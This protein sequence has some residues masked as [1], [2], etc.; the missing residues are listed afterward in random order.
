MKS[1]KTTIIG[2]LLAGVSFLGIYQSNGGNLSDW[3]QWVIP[4]LIAVLGYLAKDS[5]VTGPVKAIGFMLA[6]SV[7]LTSCGGIT[8]A[9][10]ERA[11]LDIALASVS[12]YAQGGKAGAASGGLN[13][14]TSNL[15]ALRY[16]NAKNPVNVEP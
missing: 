7:L 10:A 16:K 13:A 11:A 4:F 12:G 9:D 2:A 14:A 6:C 15:E 8:K 1:Y 5:N 3:K